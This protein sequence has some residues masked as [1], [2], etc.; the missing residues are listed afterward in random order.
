MKQPVMR[1]THS[2]IRTVFSD[3][4]LGTARIQQDLEHVGEGTAI[5]RFS[6][7]EGLAAEEDH[8]SDAD[9]HSRDDVASDKADV[10]LNV[11]NAS[12]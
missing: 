10:L 9:T 12:Q 6:D 1:I 5:G 4:L 2:P 7:E 3:S 8:E 11:G